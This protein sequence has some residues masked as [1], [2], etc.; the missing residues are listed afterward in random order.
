M[1]K[2]VLD[3]RV[4][5]VQPDTELFYAAKEAEQVVNLLDANILTGSVHVDDLVNRVRD[6]QPQ[7]IIISSHGKN[8]GILL[9]DGIIGPSDLKKIFSTSDSL[10][11]VY[12]NTCSS[13][14]T[15][16]SIHRSM[17]VDFIFSLAEVPDKHAFVS[18]STFAYHIS[19]GHTYGSAWFESKGGNG[20]DFMFL[21]SVAALRGNG[22]GENMPLEDN[23]SRPNING[24]GRLNN[25]HDEVVQLGYLIYG[26]EK[27]QLP[28]LVNSVASLQRDVSFIKMAVW[29][30]VLLVFLILI[31]GI[32]AWIGT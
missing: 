2:P 10:E 15:A 18:M 32:V 29:L 13:V 4:L 20:S 14:R 17:P 22:D 11:C 21:P 8:D 12:L 6:F 23:E 7:L 26:N 25:I 24:D 9:S 3:K 19:E 16:L 28:G 27:W 30:L 1:R 5:F 31:A